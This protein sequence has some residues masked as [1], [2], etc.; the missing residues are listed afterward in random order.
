[1]TSF[2]VNQDV[3][4]GPLAQLQCPKGIKDLGTS[5]P[6]LPDGFP[7]ALH[8]RMSWTGSQYKD[9]DTYA[10]LLDS[11]D[12]EELDAALSHFKSTF[13]VAHRLT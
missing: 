9:A 10:V 1:M 13:L 4:L 2:K 8:S 6:A 7:I 3:A 12:L 5:V 11:Q